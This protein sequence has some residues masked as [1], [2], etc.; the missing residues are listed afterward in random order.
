M[1]PIGR[2]RGYG[3]GRVAEATS[4][5]AGGGGGRGRGWHTK[6]KAAVEEDEGEISKQQS[7]S[8]KAL[9]EALRAFSTPQWWLIRPDSANE[10]DDGAPRAKRMKRE[11]FQQQCE[12]KHSEMAR[13]YENAMMNDSE[14]RWLR[15]VSAEGTAGDRVASLTMLIQ[16][17]PVFSS[18]YIKALLTMASKMGRSDAVMALDALKDAFIGHLLPDRKLKTLSQAEPALKGLSKTDLTQLCVVTFFEDYLKTAFAAFV[19]LLGEAAHHSIVFFK[20]KAIK[21]A[22][23]LLAAKPEQER[24]LLSLLVNKFG[25]LA[26]KVSSNTSFHL[27]RLIDS[28]PGMKAVV[29]KEIGV[30]LAR[31]NIT[32]K[33]KYFAMLFLSELKLSRERDKELAARLIHV[34]VGQLEEALKPPPK[35]KSKI[36]MQPRRKGGKPVPVRSKSRRKG[37]LLE[38]DNRIIRTLINGIQRIIPY[39]DSTVAGSPVQTETVDTLFKICHTVSSFSTR[40][41]ILS[42]LFKILISTGDLPDRFYR[43]LYEQLLHFDLFQSAHRLQAFLL[44]RK[45]V[46]VDAS[47]NR[48]VAVMRRLLQVGAGGE[49]PVAAIGLAILRELF[50]ARRAEMKLLLQSADATL[51]SKTAELGD[52]AEEE[53]FVDDDVAAERK[54]QAAEVERYQPLAREPRYAK[55]QHTPLWELFALASHVHPFVSHGAMRLLSAETFE[56]VGENP[57]QEFSTGELLEQFAYAASKPRTKQGKEAAARLPYNSEKFMRRKNILPHERFFHQYFRDGTVQEQQRRK[58]RKQKEER[59]GRR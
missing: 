17:C 15:K 55:A 12:E 30:F 20:T 9:V 57:F 41:A 43:L 23:D 59:R 11:V 16:V 53:H 1:A 3:R 28:H 13:V 31:P 2:G 56:D 49:P 34:F 32:Q 4:H 25:D 8:T 33:S 22:A 6:E 24:A 54:E 50:V 10:T 5:N 18:K 58:K 26:P 38:D 37:G 48:G 42:L 29:A 14:Q 52:D 19:Q 45:C 35:T 27:K 39:L 47:T 36:K 51:K 46:P 40:I 21:T 44:F 7:T